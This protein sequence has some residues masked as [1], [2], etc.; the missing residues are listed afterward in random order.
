MIT[1]VIHKMVTT[2]RPIQNVT[3]IGG[4]RI[5]GGI[6]HVSFCTVLQQVQRV[7][8]YSFGYKLTQLIFTLLGLCSARTTHYNR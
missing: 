7:G 4:E 5:G 6:A 2:A 8:V 3:I 1:G